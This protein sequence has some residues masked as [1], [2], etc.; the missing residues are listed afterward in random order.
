VA[1]PESAA[2][3]LAGH[4]ERVRRQQPK[5]RIVFPEG[6]DPR[7]LAA[8]ERLAR[9]GL[10]EPILIGARPAGASPWLQ[11]VDPGTSPNAA[12]YAALYAARRRGRGITEAEAART[13]R[14]PLYFAALMVA[15]GDA[16]GTVGGAS[17][18]TAETV[19]AALYTIGTA[20]GVH[21]VS[22]F[23]VIAL[24][25]RAWGHNG[26]LLMADC[27]VV[28]DPTAAQMA[29]IAIATAASAASLLGTKPV[30]ALLSFSTKG[31]ARHPEVTKVVEAFKL[32]K[33]RAPN[34]EVDGELQA[35]AAL[36][37]AVGRSKSPDSRVPGHA[38]T[39]IFPNLASGNIGYKL[40]EWMAGGAAIG[41]LLQGLA[42]PAN[43]LSRA[44]SAD[45]VYSVAV[46]TAMQCGDG[47]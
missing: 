14:R 19:R 33:A 45:E 26:L 27:A 2:A 36:V 15:A 46:I 41:P 34:L 18:T 10:V 21:T 12:R 30:V 5:R 47:K 23:F 25:N 42:K 8:A 6:G 31:S 43:D 39:L 11:F 17:N 16:D 22:G 24:P 40:T 29:D 44:C 4:V 38:N 37:E 28:V 3:F 20:P 1:I 9:E 32:V 35:D 7:V 13:A